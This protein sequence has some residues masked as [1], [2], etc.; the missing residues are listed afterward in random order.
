[1]SDRVNVVFGASISGLTAGIE[2][3]KAQIQSIRAPIDML[4]GAFTELAEVAGAAFVVERIADFAKEISEASLSTLNLAHAIGLSADDMDTF[5]EAMTA[6][7]GSAAMAGRVIERLEH[8]MSTALVVPTS[9]R[10]AGLDRDGDHHR[11][12]PGETGG[13]R[14]LSRRAAREILQLCRWPGQGGAR[15]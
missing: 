12:G 13:P 11:P 8:N 14:R 7:G 2:E 3:V 5:Q 1:M 15:L 9:Q 6:M 10:G 4:A